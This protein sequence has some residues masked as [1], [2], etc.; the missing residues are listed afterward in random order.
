MSSFAQFSQLQKRTL[1]LEAVVLISAVVVESRLVYLQVIK[2]SDYRQMAFHQ[3]FSQKETEP[4]RG[5]IEDRNGTLLA[6]NI[7]LFNVCAH[8]DQIT[9]KSQTAAVL[10]RALGQSYGSILSKLT[11]GKSFVWLARQVPFE[12]SEAVESLKLEG[13]EAYREQRRFYPDHNMASHVVGFA[14]LDNQ[15]LD[16][17]ERFYDK[18][19][20]GKKGMVMA[21][22]DARGRTVVADSKQVKASVDGLNVVTTLDTTLQHIAQVELVKAYEK[23]RCKAASIIMMDPKTGEILAL[24]NCPDYDPNHFKDSTPDV[25]KNRVVNNEFEPGSTFKL[26][27]AVG[28]LEEGVVTEEDK[29]FCENG[30]YKTLYGRVVTDHEKHGWLT[31]REVFGYSSNIGMVKVGA[32]LGKDNLYRYCQKFGIGQTTG[33]DLPGEADGKLRTPDKWSG[34]SMTTIPYG[35]EVSATPIQILNAY[36]AI[37]NGGVMMKPYVMKEMRTR[38]G[39]LVKENHPE[40]IRRV[41]SAKTARRITEMMKWVV[42]KGTGTAVFLPSYPIAGKTGTAY[43]FMNGHYSRYNYVSS[44]VGFVPADNPKFVIYVSL[45]DPRG[46]YWGGYTAGPVFK[47]VAKRALAYALVPSVNPDS[48]ITVNNDKRTIPAF[49]GLTE[50]QS[51]WLAEQSGMK[52]KFDGKGERVVTQSLKAGSPLTGDNGKPVKVALTLGESVTSQAKGVM[53]DLK[54]KTKRQAL[55]MLAPL[56]VRV[57]FKGSG[58]V[59][60]QFPPPGRVLQS[61]AP[62][63]LN[64]DLPITRAPAGR[65]NS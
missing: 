1:F 7:D 46:I 41:C 39:S 30:A 58:I 5:I 65:E 37:A 10:A 63:E 42:E 15:G 8:P 27:T 33:I 51:R 45:D 6:M 32:K 36:A 48:T 47:E 22:R 64:C 3:Q 2:H 28:A 56:G 24:A 31:F 26:V 49:V 18:N 14:G 13:V 43:K 40:K 62:C 12:R 61:N 20:M 59:K 54:G 38:A 25:W 21:E 53:P 23:F 60:A 52:L 35:Y 4:S 19:L 44:F 11:N 9:D 55:A 17:L 57:N 50:S 16:G 34:I 29:F